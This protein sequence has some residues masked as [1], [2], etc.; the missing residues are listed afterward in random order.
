MMEGLGGMRPRSF[1]ALPARPVL[2]Q[3]ARTLRAA[4]RLFTSTPPAVARCTA[5]KTQSVTKRTR[6]LL[7]LSR[8]LQRK[9]QKAHQAAAAQS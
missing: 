7:D 9:K 1:V 2:N 4:C 3:L 6:S 5:C 8:L